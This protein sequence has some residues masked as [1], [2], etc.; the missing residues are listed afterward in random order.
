MQGAYPK[1]V[2]HERETSQQQS[3]SPISVLQTRYMC[4]LND[5]F[6]SKIKISI[7]QFKSDTVINSKQSIQIR[8]INSNHFHP[9]P[10]HVKAITVS[11][12]QMGKA[13]CVLMKFRCP[14]CDY[15]SLGKQWSQKDPN[16]NLNQ[17]GNKKFTVLTGSNKELSIK[18]QWDTIISWFIIWDRII[19]IRW[20]VR[21]MKSLQQFGEAVLVIFLRSSWN[22]ELLSR[23]VLAR[24]N[25]HVVLIEGLWRGV[26]SSF[27][28]GETCKVPFFDI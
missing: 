3:S 20:Q 10:F 8:F 21:S 5:P 13:S 26:A 23:F 9:Q 18:R 28:Q 14:G 17:F 27:I 19:L 4:S 12:L 1:K 16:Q 15:A 2:I 11:L 7:N 6:F 24:I 22:G 25:V